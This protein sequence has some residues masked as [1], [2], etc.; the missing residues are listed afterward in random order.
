MSCMNTYAIDGKKIPEKT[1]PILGHYCVSR[2]QLDVARS[3]RHNATH[4]DQSEKVQNEPLGL[5]GSDTKYTELLRS[6]TTVL[7]P[8]VVRNVLQ[9]IPLS[10]PADVLVSGEEIERRPVAYPHFQWRI[11]SFP[12]PLV[13]NFYGPSPS[14]PGSG[15]GWRFIPKRLLF[16]DRKREADVKANN[17]S[18]H[19]LQFSAPLTLSLTTQSGSMVLDSAERKYRCVDGKRD[20]FHCSNLLK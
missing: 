14:R 13:P 16:S 11:Y 12:F 7:T 3:M 5:V 1:N 17:L 9:I 4:A 18:C 2:N 10:H 20:D 15:N 6:I 19:S 8:L